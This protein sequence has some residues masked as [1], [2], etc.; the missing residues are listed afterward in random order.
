MKQIVMKSGAKVWWRN[1]GLVLAA[2]VFSGCAFSPQAKEARFLEAGKK[3]LAKQEY[4]RAILQFRN[5]IRVKKDDAEAYYQ[6]G[7]A[8]LG[9]RDGKSAAIAFATAVSVDGKHMGAKLKLSEL[10]IA[11]SSDKDILTSA[12]QRLTDLLKGAPDNPDVLNALAVAEWQLGHATDAERHLQRILVTAPQNL[13][14]A[15]NLAGI[16]R[17]QKDFRGAEQV[18][19]K[20]AS[21]QPPAANAFVALAEFYVLMKRHGDAEIQFRRALQV[22]PKHAVAMY[23]LANLLL[24]I[25]KRDQADPLYRQLSYI[26]DRQYKTIYAVF[27]FQTGKTQEAIKE[28]ERLAKQDSND[29]TARSMLVEAYWKANRQAEADAVLERALKSN[30]KDIEALTQRSAVLLGLGRNSEALENLKQVLRLRPDSGEAHFLLSRVHRAN[31]NRLSE[32]QELG[33]ALRLRPD[34]LQARLDLSRSLIAAKSPKAALDIMTANDFPAAQR[35]SL[36]A[37]VQRNW[38]LLAVSDGAAF[39]KEVEAGLALARHPDLLAQDAIVKMAERNFA[40]ARAS[41]DEALDKNPQDLRALDLMVMTYRVQKQPEGVLPKLRALA[42]RHASSPAIQNVL[43][44]WFVASGDRDQARAAYTAALR[45]KTDYIPA[46]VGMAKIDL[47]VGR[48]DEAR[49]A[50]NT[51]A[52][53]YPKNPM[54]NILL[55]NLEHLSGNRGKALGHYR[56]ALEADGQNAMALN[57]VAYLLA[58][59]ANK[60]D[61]ALNYAQRAKEI[62]PDDPEVEDT[63]GWVLFK[64]GLYDVAIGH[65]EASVAKR[66]TAQ[67]QYHLAMTYLK[68]GN[69]KRGEQA[70][71]AAVRERLPEALQLQAQLQA[72]AV[73]TGESR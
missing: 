1:T 14:A 13:K 72:G 10:A 43:G 51:L 39:R 49:K 57:N 11:T 52:S 56:K 4:T 16:L 2:L 25:G 61:E 24:S 40:G 62:S 37:I 46:M 15:I 55:G 30:P 63:L 7:L 29:R 64:K 44:E 41:L 68:M 31:G 45:L 33:E 67:G 48:L 23:D 9:A 42:V 66:S 70:L 17:A 38:A 35:Q 59:F 69:R 27:L 8:Y 6:L 36:P 65:L 20:A 60:P 50:L 54:I 47:A 32:R 19:I 3:A 53:S 73:K 12:Q 18:L 58:D 22:E 28:F 21:G 71:Q 34:L 26:G 5:A